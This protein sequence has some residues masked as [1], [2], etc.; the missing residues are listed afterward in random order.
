MSTT[1]FTDNQLQS[2]IGNVLRYGVL[3]ALTVTLLGGIIL[4]AKDSQQVVSFSTFVEKDQN[5][6]VVFKTIF[7]GVKE[8]NGESIIF[9]GILLLFL[10]PA[11][12]LLLSLFSFILE[13][14]AMY[15][16]I[17]LIVIAVII[18]SVSFGFSH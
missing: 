4:L 9:L 15:V 11:L 5:L 12:R 6:F 14:D 2:I 10:T 13:K 1:K 17:T 18:L 8:W 7:Q 3:S 16:V